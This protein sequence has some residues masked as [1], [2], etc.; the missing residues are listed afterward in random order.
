MKRSKLTGTLAVGGGLKHA[1]IPYIIVG[2][3]DNGYAKGDILDANYV[4]ERV[5]DLETPKQQ[6]KIIR[7]LDNVYSIL[8]QVN[9]FGVKLLKLIRRQLFGQMLQVQQYNNYV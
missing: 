2:E 4:F 9:Q 8:H 1:V 7:K 5:S 3:E 6:E